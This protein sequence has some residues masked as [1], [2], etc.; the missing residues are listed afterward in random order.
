MKEIMP[1]RARRGTG[2]ALVWGI[3]AGVE[4]SW[5]ARWR[6]VG[7]SI[8][9]AAGD[10]RDGLWEVR[11]TTCSRRIYEA[12]IPIIV[13]GRSQKGLGTGIPRGSSY[14][15][16]QVL[17]YLPVEDIYRPA[18]IVMITCNVTLDPKDRMQK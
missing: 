10:F 4:Q 13:W 9:G 6:S 12:A 8:W 3:Y 2:G 18:D 17:R 15:Q 14:V 1:K 7:L 16:R 11:L 5:L